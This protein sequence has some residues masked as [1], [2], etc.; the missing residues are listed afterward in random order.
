MGTNQHNSTVS[1]QS[2]NDISLADVVKKVKGLAQYLR[3]KLLLIVLMGFMGL[4][5]GLIYSIFKKPQYRAVYTFVLEEEEKG[6]LGQYAGL[7][8]LAGID[9]SGGGGGIFHGDNI[10][11]LYKS[12]NMISKTLLSTAIFNGKPQ[13]LIDRYVEFNKLREKW[14]DKPALKNINFNENPDSFSRLQ[15]SIIIDLTNTINKSI[16]NVDKPDKKLSIIEVDVF[17]KDELF[18]KEFANNIVNTVNSFYVLTKT[19]KQLQNATILQK[20]ADSVK[21]ILNSSIVGVASAADASPN[22]NPALSILRVPSQRR[23]VDVQ[24]STAVYA[25][26][27]KNLEL[28]KIQL[29]KET[30][31][32]QAIDTPVLPLMVSKLGKIKASILGFMAG[33]FLACMAAVLK[34]IF[35]KMAN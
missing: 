31:L 2:V 28:S 8:S 30:P 18:A 27:V 4:I 32:I 13:K 35:T 34:K 17:S 11:E 16:L 29:R 24:T 21:A 25:E 15:D 7:A 12:R 33:A 14:E 9:V 20:Q 22:A 10:L 3:S 1:N 6:G 26:M 19:K 5:L 23:Q